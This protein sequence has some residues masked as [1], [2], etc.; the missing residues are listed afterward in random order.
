ML[1]RSCCFYGTS[2]KLRLR[3]RCWEST[4][5]R[6]S[7]MS[8]S[9][10]PNGRICPQDTGKA[11]MQAGIPVGS[12]AGAL[13]LSASFPCQHRTSGEKLQRHSREQ[14]S[15]KNVPL[16]TQPAK[17]D[18]HAFIPGKSKAREAR[19]LHG[20]VDDQ[21]PQQKSSGS[22]HHP[23]SSRGMRRGPSPLGWMG[24]WGVP[25]AVSPCAPFPVLVWLSLKSQKCHFTKS[26]SVCTEILRKIE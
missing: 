1:F 2:W 25:Q 21:H 6:G 19:L 15:Y 17:S 14:G 16:R 12:T 4:K 11:K 9:T 5:Q 7:R 13:L 3:P 20:M 24:A 8:N 23:A 10:F 18:L 22:C 26:I